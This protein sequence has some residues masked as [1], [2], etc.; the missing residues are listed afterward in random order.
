MPSLHRLRVSARNELTSDSVA[1]HLL[2]PP[3]LRKVYRFRE[4]QFLTLQA[5]IGDEVLRR[6]YSICT[7]VQD[8]ESDGV[9]RVGIRRI[10]KGRFSTWAKT[11]LKVGDSIEVMTPDGRFTPPILSAHDN[12]PRGEAAMLQGRHHLAFAGGSGITPIMAILKTR[13]RAEPQSRFTLIY[14]NRHSQSVMFLEELEDLKNTFLE[15]L[16]LIHILSEERT[17]VELHRGLLGPGKC[18]LLL[19][20]L[21]NPKSIDVAYI[22]GPEPMMLAAE[23]ALRD[24]GVDPWRILIERF[25]AGPQAASAVP[26]SVQ[27]CPTTEAR[28]G[29]ESGLA[30]EPESAPE[31]GLART[32]RITI[33]GKERSVLMDAQRTTIL[34]AGLQAGMPLPYA[35][36]AGVCCTCRAL[37]TEGEVHMDRNFSLEESELEQGFVLTCQAHPLS[38]SVSLSY[39]ER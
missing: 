9:L 3:D 2:V 31:A 27:A 33:D 15:R 34:Q 6:P 38:L 37:V 12:L 25:S 30:S 8:Y 24:A 22:C 29:L 10:A 26:R 39:D 28:S 36:Q 7:A 17:E 19:N 35:C 5:Q 14:G 4:G 18:R 16:H 20:Q 13:L 11:V 21:I 32:V 1:L 23:A